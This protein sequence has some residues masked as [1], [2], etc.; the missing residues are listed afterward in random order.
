[1]TPYHRPHRGAAGIAAA[2]LVAS[3]VACAESPADPRG[4]LLVSP[5]W[6]AEH[7]EDPNLVL[8]HVGALEDYQ[9]EHIPGAYHVSHEQMSHPSSHSPPASV[10]KRSRDS[11]CPT[12]PASWCTGG[13]NG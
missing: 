11:A 6:V 5:D 13:A 10:R 7:L 9:A 8:L 1:M 2:L 3:L 12:T 4:S